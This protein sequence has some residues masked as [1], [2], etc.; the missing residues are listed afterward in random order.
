MDEHRLSIDPEVLRRERDRLKELL[1]TVEGDQREIE[2]KMKAL[3]QRELRTKREIEALEALL[4]VDDARVE[5]EKAA[6]APP[7]AA[8]T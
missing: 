5:D 1:R 7:A 6:N 3:R 4:S 2:L 8:K